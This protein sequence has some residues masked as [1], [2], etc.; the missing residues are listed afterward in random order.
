M[1]SYTELLRNNLKVH[2]CPFCDWFGSLCLCCIQ[3][4]S[5]LHPICV[6]SM[7]AFA[8]KVQLMLKLM[9]CHFEA[10]SDLCV[11]VQ[12]HNNN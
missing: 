9:F 4:A 10:F 8:F 5:V 12:L 3:F 2:L 7:P 1:Y 6:C 11:A